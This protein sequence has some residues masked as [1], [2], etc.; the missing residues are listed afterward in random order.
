MDGRE[1]RSF[2]IYG[3]EDEEFSSNL[4]LFF[5]TGNQKISEKLISSDTIYS[6]KLF[7][8]LILADFRNINGK[9]VF[10]LPSLIPR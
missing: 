2:Y 7:V 1:I 4:I 9:E 6:T 5:D 10:H 3:V 8:S